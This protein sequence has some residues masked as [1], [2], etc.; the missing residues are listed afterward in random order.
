MANSNRDRLKAM[1]V[2]IA[3][4]YKTETNMSSRAIPM[5]IITT[6]Y[7]LADLMTFFDLYNAENWDLAYETLNKL[8]VLPATSASVDSKVRDFIIYSEE[9]RFF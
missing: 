4:R 6:F 7:L 8:G 5:S 9:V 1:I 2:S 3:V